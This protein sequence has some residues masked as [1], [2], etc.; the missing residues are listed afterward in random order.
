MEDKLYDFINFT[1]H[2]NP[3][4]PASMDKEDWMGESWLKHTEIQIPL[5]HS[6]YGGCVI[7]LP[8]GVDCPTN[9]KFAGQLD[10]EKISPFDK[11]GLLPKKG[12]LLFFADIKKS[13]GKVIHSDVENDDLTRVINEHEDNFFLG[14]LIEVI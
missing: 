5:G 12:Q 6:R 10:L 11:T 14:V 3:Y 13:I 9:M 2:K 8:K 1:A 7:D 4:F